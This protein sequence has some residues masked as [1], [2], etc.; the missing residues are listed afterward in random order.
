LYCKR[1]AHHD[2]QVAL[3]EVRFD[4]LVKAGGEILAEENYVWR[5]EGVRLRGGGG[6]RRRGGRRGRRR[7]RERGGGGRGRIHLA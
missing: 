2:Q 1:R 6:G 7:R 3:G 5:G 4:L